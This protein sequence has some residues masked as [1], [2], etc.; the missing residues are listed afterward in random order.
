MKSR[1]E[2]GHSFEDEFPHR[3]LKGV[4]EEGCAGEGA[5]LG[6]ASRPFG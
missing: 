4:G 3:E 6:I 5:D 1:Q 2:G